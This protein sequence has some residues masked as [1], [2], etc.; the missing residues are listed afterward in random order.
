[1]IN[2]N[3]NIYIYNDNTT[4]YFIYPSKNIKARV[5]HNCSRTAYTDPLSHS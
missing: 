1:M 3:I 4:I 2:D 5:S